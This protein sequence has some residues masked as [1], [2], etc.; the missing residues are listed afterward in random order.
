M[1]NPL[2]KTM[3]VIEDIT[4]FRYRVEH[5]VLEQLEKQIQTSEF[6]ELN[7]VLRE[8]ISLLNLALESRFSIEKTFLTRIK[9]GLKAEPGGENPEAEEVAYT[10]TP[11]DHNPA[12][13]PPRVINSGTIMVKAVQRQETA[14]VPINLNN[15]DLVQQA[16]KLEI[17][18]FRNME[19]GEE[20]LGK[21]HLAEE[22]ITLDP[23]ST[24]KLTI[25][26]ELK[27][28]FN[29]ESKYFTTLLIK[30]TEHRIFHI[31]IEFLPVDDKDA[32]SSITLM[33]ATP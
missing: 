18:P 16:V 23:Q 22:D 6:N 12:Q 29:P 13:T 15:R 10:Y 30:G 11:S 7:P 33:P 17:P 31:I 5:N 1:E 2:A 24:T 3:K 28:D 19:T 21:I 9:T 8:G 14:K 20:M 25:D 26:I 32:K 4:K 27:E